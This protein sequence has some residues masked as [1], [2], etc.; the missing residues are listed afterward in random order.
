ME[1]TIFNERENTTTKHTFS[2]N[3]VWE[4]LSVLGINP[5]TVLVVRNGEVITEQETLHD[6]DQ[7]KILS[8][9]SGG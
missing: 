9:I 1:L 3:S 8:V 6:K 2:K 5:E 4:L 7:L